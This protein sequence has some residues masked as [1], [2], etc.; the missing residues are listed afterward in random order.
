MTE[1]VIYQLSSPGRMG[2]NLPDLDVPEK[3]LG[4]L[5]PQGSVRENLNLPEVSEPEAVRHF[6]RLSIL[7]HHV[8][9]GFYPLGSCTMKYNPKINE[10]V[11]RFAGFAQIHPLQPEETVQGALKLMYQLRTCL[12]EIAGMDEITLQPSA[13]AQG[14]LAG[15]LMI[16]AFHQKNKEK[17]TQVIIP[18]SA[19]GT[20]PASLTI[21]G[22]ELVQV[23]S[24]EQGI[25]DVDELKKVVSKETA[26][27]MLTNPNT[28]GLFEK[29]ILEIAK[30]IHDAGALLYM[31]GANLNALL[32]IVRPGDMGFDVVHFNLH[33][34]FSTPHGGGGPGAGP[35]GVK[36]KLE[37][38]LPVPIVAKE[39]DKSG[40][41]TFY[42]DYKRANSIG[43]LQAFYGNFAVLVRA[44]TYILA[45]GPDGLRKVAEDA[46][47]NANYL[48]HH[49][50]EYYHLPYPEKC[51][52]EL[53]LSGIKQKAKGVKTMDIAKRLLDFGMHAPTVY[54]PL[55]VPEALMIEPTESE[56]KESLD[57][58]IEVMIKIAN[59]VK[60]NPEIVR[61]APH[62]TP[63]ARLDEVKAAKDLDVRWRG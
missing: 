18:D 8:D 40:K 55:I 36:K 30:I 1:K 54:F 16:K 56:S 34:T 41:E 7:N 59:E 2:A 21:A 61:E 24:N 3:P 39:V 48:L 53:V 49:L 32:G 35:V 6:V 28:L 4:S 44:L 57:E 19:H 31:D 29:D 43:K 60:T 37:P 10:Y 62:N 45:N 58:F 15:L 33:K 14:E 13:G 22:F 50:K 11:A 17:R 63:V 47:I 38:F 20:N 46:I 25:V 51:M 26:A 52:H 23:K 12:L 5:L 9:K 27:F 42:L